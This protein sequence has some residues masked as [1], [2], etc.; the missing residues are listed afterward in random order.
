MSFDNDGR[1]AAADLI[2]TVHRTGRRALNADNLAKGVSF[3][4]TG[5]DTYIA[6]AG[7]LSKR[8]RNAARI[9]DA[10]A[11]AAASVGQLDDVAA[12]RVIHRGG[13]WPEPM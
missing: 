3:F 6:D 8:A 11:K 1:E 12:I 10:V 7:R 5:F 4:D 2:K 9:A 13:P